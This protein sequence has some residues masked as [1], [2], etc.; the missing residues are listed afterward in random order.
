ML[1]EGKSSIK[2]NIEQVAPGNTTLN[3]NVIKLLLMLLGSES[4]R[5]CVKTL[6]ASSRCICE[7][8]FQKRRCI[9]VV[10]SEEEWHKGHL[11]MNVQGQGSHSR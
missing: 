3:L 4:L 10:G 9:C 11:E 5:N 1:S 2:V 7:I 8:A 6:L